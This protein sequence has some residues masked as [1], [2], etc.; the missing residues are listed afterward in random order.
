M[1]KEAEDAISGMALKAA[2]NEEMENKSR[3]RAGGGAL[4]T[5]SSRCTLVLRLELEPRMAQC[6]EQGERGLS[7][8]ELTECEAGLGAPALL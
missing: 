4:L 5:G 8:L 1:R 7:H 2:L 6:S 3:S